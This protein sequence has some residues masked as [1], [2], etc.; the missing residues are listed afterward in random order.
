MIPAST[1][2]ETLM[3]RRYINIDTLS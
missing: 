1:D 2:I 3:V